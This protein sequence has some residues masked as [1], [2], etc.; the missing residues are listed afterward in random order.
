MSL[1]CEESSVVAASATE[2]VV[3]SAA[4]EAVAAETFKNERLDIGFKLIS[5][6]FS[7]CLCY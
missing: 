2:A 4:T 1:D 3:E 5:H 6:P 7:F